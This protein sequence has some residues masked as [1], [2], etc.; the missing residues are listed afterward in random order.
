MAHKVLMEGDWIEMDGIGNRE[1]QLHL[2]MF[3]V[4][5]TIGFSGAFCGE[6]NPKVK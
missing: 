1:A 2:S 4:P 5:L 3:A 6:E